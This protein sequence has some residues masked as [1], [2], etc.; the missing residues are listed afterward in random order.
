MLVT[1][2]GVRYCLINWWQGNLCRF[3]FPPQWSR[4][5]VLFKLSAIEKIIWWDFA[6]SSLL[7]VLLGFSWDVDSTAKATLRELRCEARLPSLEFIHRGTSIYG[8]LCQNLCT[9]PECICCWGREVN[10]GSST[11]NCINTLPSLPTRI[12]A[13]GQRSIL[14]LILLSGLDF[15]VSICYQLC[16]FSSS[17]SRHTH[18]HPLQF[19]LSPKHQCSSFQ[20]SISESWDARGKLKWRWPK[21]SSQLKT[22]HIRVT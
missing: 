19:Q 17:G 15:I 11:W 20:G 22:C 8:C 2:E 4:D 13:W 12:K 5:L 18:S 6:Y 21:T 7:W 3:S 16:S 1:L 10:Q 14:H 9:N